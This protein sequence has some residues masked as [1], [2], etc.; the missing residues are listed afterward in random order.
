MPKVAIPKSAFDDAPDWTGGNF[1]AIPPGV[2]V[3]FEIVPNA[4]TGQTGRFGNY[5]VDD[6]SQHDYLVVDCECVEG[7]GPN[8]DGAGLVHGEFFDLN[9]EGQMGKFRNFLEKI[10]VYADYH[11]EWDTEELRGVRFRADVT[12]FTNKKGQEKSSLTYKTIIP[13]GSPA[14]PAKP[15]GRSPAAPRR[16][17]RGGAAR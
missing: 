7:V 14:E 13:E 10:G 9:D 11:E 4:Q 16:A 8:G 2:G 6:G 17:G 12:N 3:L 5:E 1:P 15:K